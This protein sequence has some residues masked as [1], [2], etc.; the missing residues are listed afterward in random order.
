MGALEQS[1]GGGARDR[2]NNARS[3]SE[4]T[5]PVTATSIEVSMYWYSLVERTV[6]AAIARRTNGC[7]GKG[8]EDLRKGVAG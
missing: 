7:R 1:V 2:S 6:C 8:V 5:D 4:E 3:T